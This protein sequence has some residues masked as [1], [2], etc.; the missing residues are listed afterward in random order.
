MSSY[1]NIE[2]NRIKWE[3]EKVSR[4]GQQARRDTRGHEIHRFKQARAN[5][6]FENKR[7]K[8]SWADET[9]CSQRKQAGTQL[10][11]HC[12]CVILRTLVSFAYLLYGVRERLGLSPVWLE[13]WRAQFLISSLRHSVSFHFFF[14]LP[15]LV[16]LN[17][18][19][20]NIN[21]VLN[22]P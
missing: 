19:L 13:I 6:A 5:M 18:P 15:T 1:V 12:L 22:I 17:S 8:A 2:I 16:H 4:I 11:S 21:P 7:D 10:S 9:T 3:R 14:F 20:A